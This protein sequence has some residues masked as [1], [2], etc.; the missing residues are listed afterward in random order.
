MCLPTATPELAVVMP[1]DIETKTSITQR[2]VTFGYIE[3]CD[4]CE[5]HHFDEEQM[6]DM[7]YT[8]ADLKDFRR[9]AKKILKDVN[10]MDETDCYR[11]LEVFEN[12]NRSHRYQTCVMPVLQ[13]QEDLWDMDIEDPIGLQSYAVSL[14]R[15]C[16]E[17]A[18]KRGF[19]DSAEACA[20]H[21]ESF[22]CSTVESFFDE[23]TACICQSSD[24]R[25]SSEEMTAQAA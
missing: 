7:W 8:K 19:Q 16:V 24:V 18:I 10:A 1:Q 20:V 3:E 4:A 21:Q 25:N 17:A 6:A 14:N 12:G 15:K 11:G 22:E 13:L 23:L 5:H 2:R 9:H